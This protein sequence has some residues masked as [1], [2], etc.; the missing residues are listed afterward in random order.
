M[1]KTKCPFP[2]GIRERAVRMVPDHQ[3]E[4]ATQWTTICSIA[5]KIGCSGKT[6]RNRV[7]QSERD[8][9]FTCRIDERAGRHTGRADRRF[10]ADRPVVSA[11]SMRP[12]IVIRTGR[13]RAS[14]V[15]PRSASRSAGCFKENFGVD[16]V[17]KAWRQIAPRSEHARLPRCGWPQRPCPCAH[18]ARQLK[19]PGSDSNAGS[20]APWSKPT[21][22]PTREN[23]YHQFHRRRIGSP[24]ATHTDRS[25]RK[26]GRFSRGSGRVVWG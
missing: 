2:A 14:S 9:G 25:A 11:A 15:T 18:Q 1:T 20:I 8:R 22:P 10:A 19:C 7:R 5:G 3:G 24:V 21:F 6:L 23:T 4:H 16:G 12:V 17:R 13:Q 26:P